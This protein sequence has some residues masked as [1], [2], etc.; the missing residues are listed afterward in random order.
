L[1]TDKRKCVT[2]NSWWRSRKMSCILHH[3]FI[4]PKWTVTDC[5][6]RLSWISCLSPITSPYPNHNDEKEHHKLVPN[7]HNINHTNNIKAHSWNTHKLELSS[8]LI[9]YCSSFSLKPSTSLL[10]QYFTRNTKAT[11]KLHSSTY[12]TK[13]LACTAHNSYDLIRQLNLS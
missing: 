9:K 11:T 10:V 1:V 12:K 6:F 8:Q 7:H 2:V 3:T 4:G 5:F 13:M